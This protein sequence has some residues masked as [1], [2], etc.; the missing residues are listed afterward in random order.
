MKYTN[1][2]KESA[3]NFKDVLRNKNQVHGSKTDVDEMW[4]DLVVGCKCRAI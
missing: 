3:K 2:K 1:L 4:I